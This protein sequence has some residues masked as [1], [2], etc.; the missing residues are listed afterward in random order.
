MILGVIFLCV[1]ILVL[2]SA[3]CCTILEYLNVNNFSDFL[4]WMDNIFPPHAMYE[5]TEMN[6][7]GCF[8]C[9]VL[10]MFLLLP[11][12][13]VYLVYILF[14]IGR[15][16]EYKV[17]E[18]IEYYRGYIIRKNQRKDYTEICKDK[19]CVD[20]VLGVSEASIKYTKLK[21]DK[22]IKGTEK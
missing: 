4:K 3:V 14:H 2:W 10:F 8:V 12:M 11:L 22:L 7:V 1:V 19:Q 16:D 13:I 9:T 5:N 21:I 6:E 18:D 15:K 17:T 20:R